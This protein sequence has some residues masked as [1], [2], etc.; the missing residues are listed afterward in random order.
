VRFNAKFTRYSDGYDVS[1]YILRNWLE[2]RYRPD[3]YNDG[4][5]RVTY[6]KG[7]AAHIESSSMNILQKYTYNF[8]T[9]SGVLRRYLAL[10]EEISYTINTAGGATSKTNYLILTGRYNPTDKITL[11]GSLKRDE[12]D[13]GPVTFFYNVGVSAD[14]KLLSA[15]IDYALAKRDLDAIKEK[16]L[17]A[18]V[19]RTF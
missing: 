12:A 11:Y 9:R 15:S 13:P 8:F 6:D 18:T 16:K 10:S 2:V 3:R 19:R 1:D 4:F 7:R 17:S 14:F 5:F